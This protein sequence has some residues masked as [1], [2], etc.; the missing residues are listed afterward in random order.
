MLGPHQFFPD[1]LNIAD[2]ASLC[3]SPNIV[4]EL[5]GPWLALLAKEQHVSFET[6]DL[7][8][9]VLA[10][11]P[12]TYVTP[13]PIQQQAIPQV[14][15]GGDVLGLAQTGTG[16]TAAFALPILTR[17]MRGPRKQV[18][19]LVV[20]PTRELAQ[21]ICETFEI[22]GEQT[23]LRAITIFGGLSMHGQIQQLRRGVEI[24][25]G[26]PGRLVDH[27]ERGTL[28]LSTVE[29]LV[30][31]EA[32]QMFDMGFLPSIRRLL[33]ALPYHRQNLMFSATMPKEVERLAFD[34]LRQPS[35]IKIGKR[36]PTSLVAHYV[37]PVDQSKKTDLLLK[38]LDETNSG[39]VLV[40]TRTKHRAKRLAA[41]L[42]NAGHSASAIQGN[43]SQQK[44]QA[45]L[46]GF[47]SGQYRILVATDIAARGI[48]VESVTHVIN[49]DIP[50]TVE[51]YTHRIGRTGRAERTGDALTFITNEDQRTVQ[52]IERVLGAQIE[53][54][55]V[56]GFSSPQQ[57]S[58]Q[59]RPRQ[60]QGRNR[61]H[62]GN[63]RDNRR[64][65]SES[66]HRQEQGQGERPFSQAPK[67]R[68]FRRRRSWGRGPERR[69][70]QQ[71]SSSGQQF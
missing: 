11:I 71:R 29:V 42:I 66:G 8:P 62:Q 25:V 65:T 20:A 12:P 34:V 64:N 58:S 14:L 7:H 48:D 23:G 61:Q 67:G 69:G 26:C 3:R 19:A 16:K 43:L 49:F 45:A 51:A 55:F 24:V 10:A 2:Y 53:R 31:D 18:R 21:Q 50:D 63:R 27:V 37:Y 39:S 38:V 1:S 6:F 36:A 28:D 35:E 59:S 68:N 44:R 54:R 70:S 46:G 22:L 47:R 9:S 52:A 33:A 41:A 57:S 15:A 40:F 60:Q 30:L 5:G 56:E 13:T 4:F 32:D 17:L